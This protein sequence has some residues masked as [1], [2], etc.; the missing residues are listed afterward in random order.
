MK[1][2]TI[3]TTKLAM[4][5]MKRLSDDFGCHPTELLE[6]LVFMSVAGNIERADIAQALGIVR[7]K[8]T[9]WVGENISEELAYFARLERLAREAGDVTTAEQAQANIR[10]L[11]G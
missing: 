8:T 10:R 3:T 11:K 1:K 7:E 9:G 6:A 5:R 4:A 2:I